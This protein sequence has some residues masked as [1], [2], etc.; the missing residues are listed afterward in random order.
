MK[1]FVLLQR[2]GCIQWCSNLL[3]VFHHFACKPTLHSKRSFSTI[4]GQSQLDIYS[5]H[6]SHTEMHIRDDIKTILLRFAQFPSEAQL[7]NLIFQ[8]RWTKLYKVKL[9]GD[10]SAAKGEENWSHNNQQ[11]KETKAGPIAHLSQTALS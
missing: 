5:L 9:N 7:N 1:L 4:N 3:P 2:H 10:G 8:T 6:P 11:I